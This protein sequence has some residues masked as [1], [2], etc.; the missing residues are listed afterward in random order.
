MSDK[1]S[2]EINAEN[3]DPRTKSRKWGMKL[4]TILIAGVLVLAGG[5]TVFSV[6]TANA[7]AEETAR[8][9]AAALK[10]ST[11]GARASTAAIATADQTLETVE[12]VTLPGDEAWMSTEYAARAGAEAISSGFSC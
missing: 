11:T 8:Q 5:I 3:T 9:C 7:A 6:N 2:T 10:G 12:S 4:V 1:T